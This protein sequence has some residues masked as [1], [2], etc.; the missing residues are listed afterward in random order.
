MDMNGDG[1]ITQA[2]VNLLKTQCTYRNCAVPAIKPKTSTLTAPVAHSAPGALGGA[3]SI[4]W[5]PVS[6][7]ADYLVYRITCSPSESSPPPSVPLAAAEACSQPQAPSVCSMSPQVAAGAV[8]A[9]FG[10]PSAP[11]FLGRFS[12]TTYGETAPNTLQA[13]YFVIA[14][15]SLGNLSSPSNVV[16]GPSFATQ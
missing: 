8:S 7:A 11:E 4:T 10:Y 9:A 14:E 6:G 16:G 1:K 5:S 13:L 3:I 2:D 15:D 12:N